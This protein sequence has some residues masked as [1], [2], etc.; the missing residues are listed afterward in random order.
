MYPGIWPPWLCCIFVLRLKY[1]R[2]GVQ[3]GKLSISSRP[4]PLTD[5]RYVDEYLRLEIRCAFY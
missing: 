1:S 4:W 2:V 3:Y 5:N